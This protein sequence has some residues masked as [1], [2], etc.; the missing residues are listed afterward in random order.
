MSHACKGTYGRVRVR[1]V[2]I[3]FARGQRTM[4]VVFCM[5]TE[6][7][8]CYMYEPS[9]ESLRQLMSVSTLN[10]SWR[11]AGTVNQV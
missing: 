1:L 2:L 11:Y 10:Q 8:C 3:V 4:I 5:V 9:S 7:S 6:F